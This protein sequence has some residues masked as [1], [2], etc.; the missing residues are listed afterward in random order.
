MPRNARKGKHLEQPAKR[1]DDEQGRE[2]VER[3]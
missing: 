1:H 3:Y 2:E